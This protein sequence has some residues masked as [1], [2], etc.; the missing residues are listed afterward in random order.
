MKNIKISL[1]LISSLAFAS[2]T[3]IAEEVYGDNS[4]EQAAVSSVEASKQDMLVKLNKACGTQ[5]AATIQWKSYA[6]FSKADLHDR[7]LD[8]VYQIVDSQ[9]LDVLHHI[10]SGCESDTFYK[11]NVAKK[12]K[13][14]IFTPVKGEVSLKNPSHNYKLVNGTLNVNYN[15][16]TSNDS[17]NEVRKIF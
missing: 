15:F 7:T 3:T 8:N 4:A 6:G 16:E 11:K 9:A 14:I 5:V 10:T 12:L 2:T 1:L 13:N 17:I